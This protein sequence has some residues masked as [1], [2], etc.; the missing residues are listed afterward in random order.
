MY[1]RNLSLKFTII[2]AGASGCA[3]AFLLDKLG[4]KTILVHNGKNILDGSSAWV[5]YIWHVTGAEYFRHGHRETGIRCME[6]DFAMRALKLPAEFFS[7]KLESSFYVSRKSDSDDAPDDSH[8]PRNEFST[9]ME[10]MRNHFAENIFYPYVEFL[11]SEAAS[12]GQKILSDEEAYALATQ[13]IGHNPVTFAREIKPE[14]RLAKDIVTGYDVAGKGINM[15]HLF[16]YY[17]AILKQSNISFINN[18]TLETANRLEDETYE[19]MLSN[20]ETLNTDCLLLAASI[21]NTELTNKIPGSIASV[22]GTYYANVMT[23]FTLPE[24]LTD[25][26]INHIHFTLQQEFGA[27]FTCV[28][29][30]ERRYVVYKPSP[31]Q[32][33][34]KERHFYNSKD[35]PVPIDEWES[36]TKENTS[37]L[38][39]LKIIELVS[40]TYTVLKHAKFLHCE[41]GYVFNVASA[42]SKGGS[43]RSVRTLGGK[44]I[45]PNVHVIH[46]PKLTNSFLAGLESVHQMLLSA[47]EPG[48][49]THKEH[50]VGPSKIDV[51]ELSKHISFDNIPDVNRADAINS[52]IAHRLPLSMVNPIAPEFFV[53]PLMLTERSSFAEKLEKDTKE[54][55]LVN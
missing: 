6:G 36:R 3:A 47:G 33:S 40:E 25:E 2:G 14:G 46:A 1:D 19:L 20:G 17:H 7:T 29:A 54:P 30:R 5:S 49:P 10:F 53:R 55:A 42:D 26:Q 45:A 28:D 38:S 39:G 52:A 24:T 43:I 16:A 41:E 4:Y 18:S 32:G 22:T 31:N 15:P 21:S 23:H 44:K 11:K 35:N 48:L 27:A 9:N 51:M 34:Q 37:E 50:G 8:V 12:Y 13:I